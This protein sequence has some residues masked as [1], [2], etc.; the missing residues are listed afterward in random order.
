MSPTAEQDH[1][2]DSSEKSIRERRQNRRAIINGKVIPVK[3]KIL[4]AECLCLNALAE[5]ICSDKF[6]SKRK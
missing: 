1:V 4:R 6:N 5:Y 2:S 3:K